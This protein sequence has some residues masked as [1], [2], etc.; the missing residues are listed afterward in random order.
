MRMGTTAL[1]GKHQKWPFLG[2]GECFAKSF[3]GSV[4]HRACSA[5]ASITP[6]TSALPPKPLFFWWLLLGQGGAWWELPGGRDGGEFLEEPEGCTGQGS[7]LLDLF[8]A[9]QRAARNPK[10]R[11]RRRKRR[12]IRKRRR[13]ISITRRMLFRHPPILLQTGMR[14]SWVGMGAEPWSQGGGPGP[15]G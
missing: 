7:S 13:R 1:V 6:K 5:S 8:P 12:N 15:G 3:Y 2:R 4:C 14:G 11:K 9:D 10:R